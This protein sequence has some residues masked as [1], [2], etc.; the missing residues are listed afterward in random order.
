M[1]FDV[2]NSILDPEMVGEV[3]EEMKY[4]AFDGM[5]MMRVTH[6]MG[7]NKELVDRVIFIDD[8][9]I[10]EQGSPQLIFDVA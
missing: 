8:N 10:V 3:L 6:Y 2:A 1:L 5:T 4:F 9:V 7:F